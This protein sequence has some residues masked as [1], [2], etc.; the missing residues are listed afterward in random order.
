MSSKS[1]WHRSHLA[2]A[3]EYF[4]P[5]GLLMPA[6]NIAA[7]R[8]ISSAHITF[9]QSFQLCPEA[10]RIIASAPWRRISALERMGWCRT[11]PSD[12]T[13]GASLTGTPATSNSSGV[14]ML[15]IRIY[16]ILRV[17]RRDDRS[18]DRFAAAGF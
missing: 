1:L 17:T 15:D 7:V 2:N 4:R 5:V 12:T 8:A 16:G 14:R 18:P 10:S 11:N 13:R 3:S 9:T 6:S